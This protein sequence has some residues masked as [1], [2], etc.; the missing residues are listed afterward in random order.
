MSKLQER[1]PPVSKESG[2]PVSAMMIRVICDQFQRESGM[3][4]EILRGLDNGFMYLQSKRV[5]GCIEFVVLVL[6]V[7][8]LD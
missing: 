6:A 3:D 7:K 8:M 1:R 4:F 2:I 5:F